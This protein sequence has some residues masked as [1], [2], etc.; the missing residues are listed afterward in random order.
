MTQAPDRIFARII[1]TESGPTRTWSDSLDQ[2]DDDVP[3]YIRADLVDALHERIERLEMLEEAVRTAQRF[4][5]VQ[6]EDGRPEVVYQLDGA[7]LSRKE[8]FGA[9]PPRPAD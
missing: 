4:A 5:C 2:A 6:R 8:I 3:E 1:R 9:L 7:W